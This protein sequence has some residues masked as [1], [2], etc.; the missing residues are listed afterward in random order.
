[1]G[2]FSKVGQSATFEQIV[3]QLSESITF[4]VMTEAGAGDQ[5]QRLV[6]GGAVATREAEIRGPA[7][8]E[9]DQIHVGVQG[10]YTQ[11]GEHVYSC[12]SLRILDQRQ[13]N[14]IFDRAISEQ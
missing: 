14:E 3:R 2:P 7:D 8:A 4:S 6:V 12:Q 10:G 9:R 5:A 1:M 11:P 13:V